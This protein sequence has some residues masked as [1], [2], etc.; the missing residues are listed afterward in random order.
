MHSEIRHKGAL[1][2]STIARVN[3]VWLAACFYKVL[4]EHGLI[5]LH[6]VCDCFNVTVAE[7]SNCD[8]PDG[9]QSLTSLLSGAAQKKFANL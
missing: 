3:Q 1:R 8:R 5:C 9:P 2:L 6:T 4:L 7:L